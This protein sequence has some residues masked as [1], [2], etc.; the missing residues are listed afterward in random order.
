[1]IEDDKKPSE[2][3]SPPL[4]L[5]LFVI[6]IF[7]LF[8]LFTC[9]LCSSAFSSS[10]SSSPSSSS[11]AKSVRVGETVTIPYLILGTTEADWDELVTLAARKQNGQMMTM[12]ASGRAFIV[13][14]NT[15]A[16]VLETKSLYMIKVRILNGEHSGKIGWLSRELL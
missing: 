15:S 7:F 13:E 2:V 10:S 3:N 14:D 12:A 11:Y 9:S 1:M 5:Y 6:G 16:E 4:S 8:C